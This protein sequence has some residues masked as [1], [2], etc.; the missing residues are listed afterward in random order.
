MSRIRLTQEEFLSRVKQIWG[1]RFDFSKAIFKDTRTKVEVICP[2]HGSFFASPNNLFH[3]WGCRKCSYESNA[4]KK[5]MGKD[6]FILRA[7]EIHGW[8]Y[9]YSFVEYKN[10]ETKVC[11]VCPEHGEFWQEPWVH[12]KGSKCPKCAEKERANNRK[13]TQEEFID[14]AKTIH[15]DRY[16]YTLTEY[17]GCRELVDIICPKHGVFSIMAYSHLNGCGCQECKK[18]TISNLRRSNTQDF[19]NR[20]GEVHGDIYDY[21]KVD[22][23]GA[24]QKV[25]IVC[26]KHGGF[27]QTP[28][29]HLWGQ[30]CPSC[31]TSVGENNVALF[32]S[33]NAI[34]FVRQKTFKD[35][36]D[37]GTLFFDFYLPQYNACIEYQGI[38]HYEPIE[39]FGGQRELESLQRRDQIKR[40]YCASKGIR[41]IEIRH[42]ENVEDVLNREF[43]INNKK[44]V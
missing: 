4:D 6:L 22:Y 19:I 42:D 10:N 44:V 43:G 37:V 16:D 41:L 5:R 8:K 36:K 13:Y 15:G 14:K 11:I 39:M 26:Q 18:D 23:K 38:Q 1:D 20:A 25:E 28:A 7:R 17:H 24:L 21:S 9:D 29:A 33:K 3:G 31:H 12:L 40:D 35:C 2:K 27:W 32:L 34:E 30:G